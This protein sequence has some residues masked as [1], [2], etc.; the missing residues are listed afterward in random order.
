ARVDAVRLRLDG[1]A[2][3]LRGH[4][5]DLEANA[6]RKHRGDEVHACE[7]LRPA[8]RPR[9]GERAGGP[10]L[11]VVGVEQGE[12]RDVRARGRREELAGDPAVAL[13]RVLGR[14]VALLVAAGARRGTGG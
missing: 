13:E 10:E 5:D 7:R 2:L 14:H 11:E 3:A 1:D 6:L 4:R 9:E 8:V 12:L